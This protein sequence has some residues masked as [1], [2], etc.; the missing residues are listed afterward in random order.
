MQR[1][2][3]ESAPRSVVNRLG[4]IV[5]IGVSSGG[6]R[7][8]ERILIEIPSSFPHSILIVQHIAIDAGGY[9]VE[10]LNSCSALEIGF[11]DAGAVI[12]CGHVYFAPPGYH[13]LAE[14]EGTLSLSIDPP[15]NFS[16]PSV[17]VLFESVARAFGERVIGVILTGANAD[18][19][20]GL[21]LIKKNRGTAIVQDPS[22][23]DAKQMPT[24]AL[25]STD[26]DHVFSLEEIAAYLVNL[27]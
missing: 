10:Y 7:A 20:K 23:S 26:V 3:G 14:R 27:K 24:H 15:V 5:A 25:E 1:H 19:A 11:V 4:K 8:L 22:V 2:E 17:D 9:M 16:I 6:F 12:C 21:S 13:L 18:G